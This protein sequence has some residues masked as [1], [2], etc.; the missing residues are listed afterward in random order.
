M[1]ARPCAHAR[2]RHMGRGDCQKSRSHSDRVRAVWIRNIMQFPS[3]PTRYI[4]QHV[5]TRAQSCGPTYCL[6]V[7]VAIMPY[8]DRRDTSL[9]PRNV[10][11]HEERSACEGRREGNH[12]GV[13]RT[14]SGNRGRDN[15]H[16]CQPTQRS[17]GLLTIAR[18]A[19]TRR[20]RA[21]R[22]WPLRR[23]AGYACDAR[24]ACRPETLLG[25]RTGPHHQR[26]HR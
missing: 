3:P 19:R 24:K 9:A 4:K 26:A 8:K 17:R 18:P 11:A 10:G 6:C 14:T 1:R 2:A 16:D 20:A 22:S 21:A 15:V 12:D 13:A 7:P 23:T 25:P 5:P